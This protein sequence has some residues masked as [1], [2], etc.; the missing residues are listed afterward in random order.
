MFQPFT[1]NGGVSIEVKDSL[2][3]RKS[4]HNQSINQSISH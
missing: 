4:V 3:G 2:A 1:G